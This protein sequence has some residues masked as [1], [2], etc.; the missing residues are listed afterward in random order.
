MN[1]SD[2]MRKL[3]DIISIEDVF[4]ENLAAIDIGSVEHSRFPV[5][6]FLR[7]QAGL[8]RLRDDSA[9]HKETISKL[10]TIISGDTRD[11]Y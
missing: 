3:D 9:R 1:R 7:L 4:V 5:T 10:R 6:T 2:L 11:E 8:K